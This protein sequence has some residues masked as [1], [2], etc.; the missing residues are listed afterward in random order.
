M[1]TI[2]R[3]VL[4]VPEPRRDYTPTPKAKELQA[5]FYGA[6]HDGTYS[7]HHLTFRIVQKEES[8][9]QRLKVLLSQLGIRSW[10]YQEG[11]QRKL[12][13]L[14]STI[15]FLKEMKQLGS[16]AEKIAYVKGYF[17]AEGGIPASQAHG[18]YIQFCQK[19]KSELEELRDMLEEIGIETGVIHTP[20]W[21]VDPN[22]YRFFIRRKSL[23]RFLKVIGSFHPR[24]EKLVRFW[25]KI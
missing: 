1:R 22:Y 21:K 12:Y 13:A 11:K 23:Q 3:E 6:I 5:Y 4:V 20:S 7:K 18:L 10:I 15:P 9:L 14:E 2:P 16:R 24:K 19:N 25:M 17:D 8:W